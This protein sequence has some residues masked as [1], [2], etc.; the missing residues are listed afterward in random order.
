MLCTAD[1]REAHLHWQLGRPT[2]LGDHSVD[3][4]D[5]CALPSLCLALLLSPYA[6]HV[7]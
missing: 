7:R 5:D 2:L 4:N 3:T 6:S 1:L